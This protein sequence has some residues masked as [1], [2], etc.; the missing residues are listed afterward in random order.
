VDQNTRN[1]LANVIQKITIA[2]ETLHDS[3]IEVGLSDAQIEDWTGAL[4][5]YVDGLNYL[6]VLDDPYLP[7]KLDRAGVFRVADLAAD[8][9]SGIGQ[10]NTTRVNAAAFSLGQLPGDPTIGLP[11][12]IGKR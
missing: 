7:E 10:G 6:L 1:Q 12:P 9:A 2:T 5:S 4:L 11:P 8:L 3:G